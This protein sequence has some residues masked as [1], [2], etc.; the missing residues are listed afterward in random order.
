[1]YWQKLF[2][3]MT[4]LF[5]GGHAKI[6]DLIEQTNCRTYHF[7]VG[8]RWPL[9]GKKSW[10]AYYL[11]SQLH[12]QKRNQSLWKTVWSF[13]KVKKR[14]TTWFS[15]PTAGDLFK[16]IE[17]MILKRYQHSHIFCNAIHNSSNVEII[18]I[19]ISR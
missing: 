5:Q 10:L 14:I 11:F 17:I 2:I 3:Y 1:M 7:M 18:Q 9:G 4:V 6:E 13:L 16:R 8:K 15:N 12:S 19:S